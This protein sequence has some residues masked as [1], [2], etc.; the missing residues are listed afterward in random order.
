MSGRSRNSGLARMNSVSFDYVSARV[1]ATGGTNGIGQASH[2]PR[3]S[4][5][6]VA[7]HAVT[8][9]EIEGKLVRRITG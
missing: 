9:G 3:V 5:P 1:L 8:I 2:A 6:Y 4:F 7:Y